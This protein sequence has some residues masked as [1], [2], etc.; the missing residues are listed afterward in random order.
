MPICCQRK[1]LSS[2]EPSAL[3]ESRFILSYDENEPFEAIRTDDAETIQRIESTQ[4]IG[5]I[6]GS[7]PLTQAT[8][9]GSLK[10]I[11]ALLEGGHDPQQVDSTGRTLLHSARK[12][13]IVK[14]LLEL[15]L[16]ANATDTTGAAPLH[17]AEDAG[18]VKALIAGG[19]DPNALN[20]KGRSPLLQA[21]DYGQLKVVEALLAG[22]ADANLED[23]DGNTPLSIVLFGSQV[24]DSK[25]ERIVELLVKA[26]ADAQHPRVRDRLSGGWATPQIVQL[27][28]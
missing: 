27:L 5:K 24:A 10:V 28:Q 3:A 1:T 15:G 7:D 16:N 23:P 14:R 22:G 17:C 12:A 21:A 19:A 25:K 8:F 18:V 13:K 9:F 20:S 26:G 6:R 11:E 4:K 2:S